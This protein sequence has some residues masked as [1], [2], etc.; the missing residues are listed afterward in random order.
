M[1]KLYTIQSI[2]LKKLQHMVYI[3][4][5]SQ[6]NLTYLLFYQMIFTIMTMRKVIGKNCT[7]SC[8]LLQTKLLKDW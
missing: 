2:S 7:N 5:M 4:Q 6:D 8:L 3:S 1:F